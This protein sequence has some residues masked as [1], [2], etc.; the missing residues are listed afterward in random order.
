MGIKANGRAAVMTCPLLTTTR[1]EMTGGETR[2]WQ[3]STSWSGLDLGGLCL[4]S[5]SEM[6]FVGSS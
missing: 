2:R 5:V 1:G 6:D 4:I 3:D